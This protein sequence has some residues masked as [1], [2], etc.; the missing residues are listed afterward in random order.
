MLWTVWGCAF[1]FELQFLFEYIRKLCVCEPAQEV[2]V[3]GHQVSQLKT[4]HDTLPLHKRPGLDYAEIAKRNKVVV[5]VADA[6]LSEPKPAPRSS[7]SVERPAPRLAEMAS[8]TVDHESALS[9]QAH[10]HVSRDKSSP[11]ACA[12]AL[13]M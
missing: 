13:P 9:G 3:A 12:A 7:M 6:I 2:L 11:A 10:R 1:A 5:H 8:S 4:N